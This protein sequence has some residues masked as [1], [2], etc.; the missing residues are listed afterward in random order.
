ML[1]TS[2]EDFQRNNTFSLYDLFVHAHTHEPQSW[3]F[4]PILLLPLS[5]LPLGEIDEIHNFLSLY[6]T[7]A[8]YQIRLGSA[9]TQTRSRT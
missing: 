5:Y 8:T 7:Y 2:E 9:T 1:R 6:F 3:I 4:Y